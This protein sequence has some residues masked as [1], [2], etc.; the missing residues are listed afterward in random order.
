LTFDRPVKL[1]Q[2]ISIGSRVYKVSIGGKGGLFMAAT[3]HSTSLVIFKKLGFVGTVEIREK[4]S[5]IYGYST[6]IGFW[7][8]TN[9][10][11]FQ[12]LTRLVFFLKLEYG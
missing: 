4:I 11:D 1:N 8:E 10:E 5:K 2:N 12:A 6:D 3:D 9:Y 7:P